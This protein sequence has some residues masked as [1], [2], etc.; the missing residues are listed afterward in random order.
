MIR[1]P[2]ASVEHR[3]A[4]AVGAA[5]MSALL[6]TACATV[7]GRPREIEMPIVAVEAAPG[8][9]AAAVGGALDASGARAAFV[10]A[11]RDAA[12]FEEVAA[13]SRL[14]LSGPAAMGDLR[15]A[16]LAPEAV[17]DTTIQLDYEGGVL[18]VQDALYE[19]ARDRL[20]DLIAF[21]IEEPA[22]ARPAI[23]ALLQYVATDVGNAA[24]LVMAVSVPSAEVGDSVARMLAPA[25][26]DVLRCEPSAAGSAA[27]HLRLF[28]GPAARMFCEGGAV[29]DATVGTW[30]RAELVMGRR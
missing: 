29:S 16:F 2:R 18:V 12:W 27:E 14:Q 15:M 23:G 7:L 10:A 26:S 4:A 24:A 28:Y 22:Q 21:R 9:T 25:Y 30:L 1:L 11:R 8:V 17:G 19:I 13:S 5:L 20:L 6:V 3:R